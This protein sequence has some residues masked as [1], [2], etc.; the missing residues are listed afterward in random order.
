MKTRIRG[1]PETGPPPRSAAEPIPAATINR[2]L[3]SSA[4]L[5]PNPRPTAAPLADANTLLAVIEPVASSQAKAMAE[6]SECVGPRSIDPEADP[7]STY[8]P[9]APAATV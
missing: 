3:G 5:G 4:S 9:P 2:L 7:P 1:P 6:S 8:A